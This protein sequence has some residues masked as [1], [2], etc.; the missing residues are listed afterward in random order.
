MKIVLIIMAAWGG[1]FAVSTGAPR[2]VTPPS[3][4]QGTL[5]EAVIMVSM[6]LREADCWVSAD[7]KWVQ[8]EDGVK[9]ASG[10]GFIVQVGDAQ[11]LYTNVHNLSGATKVTFISMKGTEVKGFESLEV[12]DDPDIPD[13]AR[14]KLRTPHPAALSF[15]AGGA[16]PAHGAEV[17]AYGDSGG[18][19]AVT[20]LGGK[21]L[22]VGPGKIESDAEFIGGNSGGPLVLAGSGE[23]VGINTY[24]QFAADKN[25]RMKAG[26]RFAKGR[27]FSYRPDKIQNWKRMDFGGL[28]AEREKIN[29]VHRGTYALGIVCS[30]AMTPS[31]KGFILD[32]SK[33]EAKR[34][35]RVV[36][37]L[38]KLGDGANPLVKRIVDG[39]AEV[40]G[41]LSPSSAVSS[42]VNKAFRITFNPMQS[43][44]SK[45]GAPVAPHVVK[46]V[47]ESFYKSVLRGAE[48]TVASTDPKTM[49]PFHREALEHALA[50]RKQ[51][52]KMLQ[53][54]MDAVKDAEWGD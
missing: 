12:S 15:P 49:T 1:I 46:Q 14:L 4:K 38:S 28:A 17:V 36:A 33:A 45:P 19:K 52:L 20:L 27:R 3:I 51:V 21:I 53:E 25:D 10:S 13:V 11:Y 35:E 9:E 50:T 47:Y 16:S 2:T 32:D 39:I 6:T 31:R 23:V 29:A 18:Q 41:R 34:A 26:T 30:P 5:D 22:A 37:E 42:K 48:M 54:R 44:E 43:H 24:V 7:E 8:L 40:D